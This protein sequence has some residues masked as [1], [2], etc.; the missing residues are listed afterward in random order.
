LAEI[1]RAVAMSPAGPSRPEHHSVPYVISPI[2]FN[3]HHRVS[4]FN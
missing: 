4:D 1:S 3:C 2:H